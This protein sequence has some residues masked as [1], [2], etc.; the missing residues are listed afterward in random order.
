VYGSSTPSIRICMRR[1]GCKKQKWDVKRGEDG[2]KIT[3]KEKKRKKRKENLLTYHTFL[4]DLKESTS[5]QKK[6]HRNDLVRKNVKPKQRRKKPAV[7][8][9]LYNISASKMLF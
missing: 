4:F 5:N 6:S 3:K 2:K 7:F 8:I 1:T 9:K